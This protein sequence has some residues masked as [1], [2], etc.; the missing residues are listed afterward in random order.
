[1]LALQLPLT[2]L[3]KKSLTTELILIKDPYLS[4]LIHFNKYL[5]LSLWVPGM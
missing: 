1:M 4:S 3:Q 5:L 2:Y